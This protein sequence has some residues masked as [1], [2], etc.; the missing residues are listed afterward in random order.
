MRTVFATALL[1]AVL[2]L[3]ARAQL[4]TDLPG[5]PAPAVVYDAG[6]VPSLG[7]LFNA[8]TLRLD[9]SYELS[10]SSFGGSSLG[11]GVYTSSLRWQPSDR[12]AARVDVSAAHSPFGDDGVRSALGFDQ[13]TPAQIYLRNAE[14]AYRPTEN[15]MLRFQVQQSP[16]GSYASPYG[17]YYGG[18]GNPYGTP[19]GY[20]PY[21]GV[22]VRAQYGTGGDGGLFWR[23]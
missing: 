18:Y 6:S 7:S 15:S 1:V 4:R 8:Q 2:A 22:D 23:E 10:Y 17:S 19:Y 12:L 13:N 16:Y 14:V 3:P 21:G 9:H 11:L 20:A 5:D